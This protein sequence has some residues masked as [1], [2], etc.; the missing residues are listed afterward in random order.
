MT[1]SSNAKGIAKFFNSFEKQMSYGISSGLNNLSEHIRNSE[2]SAAQSI[3]TLRG[4]W[5]KPKTQYGFNIK[6]AK[7][8]DLTSE[9]YT[10]ADWLILHT[11]GGTKHPSK[12]FLALPTSDVKR[13]KKDIIT[14]ANKP[15]NLKGSFRAN[16]TTEN[17]KKVPAIAKKVGR[18]KNKK[19]V[20]MYWLEQNAEIKKTYDF[21]TIAEKV[22]DRNGRKY[23]LEGIEEAFRTAK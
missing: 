1:I 3:F 19:L 16:I 2:L 4:T 12:H 9:V 23:I 20:V 13:N 7:K 6:F 15:R 18:G 21:Y 10:R 11:D 22:V 14:R 8:T 5:W 17:G